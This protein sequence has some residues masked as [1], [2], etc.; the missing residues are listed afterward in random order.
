MAH[1]TSG[2]CH[3]C[4]RFLHKAIV[5]II[6]SLRSFPDE[7]REELLSLISTVF[8]ENPR[9]PQQILDI[10]TECAKKTDLASTTLTVFRYGEDRTEDVDHAIL[11]AVLKRQNLSLPEQLSLTLLW[12]RVDVARSCLFSGGRHWPVCELHSAMKDALRLN[13]VDFVECLLEN[14]V[15][16]KK[17][18]T[19]ATLEQLY[20]LDDDAQHNVRFLVEHSSPT[21]YMT[22]PDIGLIIEKLMGNAYKHYYTSRLFKNNYEKFR[23]KAQLSRLSSFHIRLVAK[24]SP[25]RPKSADWANTLQCDDDALPDFAYPFNDLI[26]WAVLTRRPEMARCMWLHGEDAMAKSLVAASIVQVNHL[27]LIDRNASFKNLLP[28]GGGLPIDTDRLYKAIA[29]IAEE[30]Y[31]EVEVAQQLREYCE[32][33]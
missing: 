10:I 3:Y 31:L 2:K 29:R 1:L 11:T 8:P 25:R 9:T 15:S 6:L 17:F 19:I 33:V 28:R 30:D 14:G 13:R 5:D 23:K 27:G 7:V 26:L 24:P 32:Y 16:M 18:L 12:N 21:S 20:N 4:Q 22:L